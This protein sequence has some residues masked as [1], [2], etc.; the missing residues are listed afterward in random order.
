MTTNYEQISHEYKRA[1][2]AP[3][4]IH[5]ERFTLL[6]LIGDVAGKSVLDLACGE[7]FLTREMKRA[8]ARRVVGADLSPAM[9]DLAR[10][11][12]KGSPL[13]IDYVVSAA[14]S[15]D[16][17]ETFDLVVAGWLLNYAKS[18]EQLL[19]MCQA[20]ARH[21]IPGGR[22]CSINND[23]DHPS[24]HAEAYRKY[25]FTKAMPQ[26]LREGAAVGY[27]IFLPDGSSFDIENYH[28]SRA[29]HQWA[30][31]SAGFQSLQFHTPRLAP[32]AVKDGDAAFWS[33]F[34]T[35]PPATFLEAVR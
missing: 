19:A 33:E 10:T 11:Q 9:I 23:D 6:E 4:R 1:K 5:I 12:E 25:G 13:G 2:Q 22:F 18:R 3:W 30:F 21:L 26:P 16:L 31:T 17:H 15:L 24:P 7:G 29:S 28:M 27:K 35:Y 34:L 14:E 32:E 8:G 20:I